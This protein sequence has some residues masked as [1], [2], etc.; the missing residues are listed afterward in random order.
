M[1]APGIGDISTS[2]RNLVNAIRSGLQLIIFFFLNSVRLEG[3]E[4]FNVEKATRIEVNS[5]AVMERTG[6]F[7][8]G[9]FVKQ[10]L[11]IVFNYKEEMESIALM[12]GCTVKYFG[13]YS[14]NR[15]YYLSRLVSP[16]F[17]NK[18]R[19]SFKS[20]QPSFN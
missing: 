18:I 14:M 19:P 8:P 3:W 5:K 6:H 20:L 16:S 7:I 11:E 1:P 12:V 13:W 4:F 9:D 10:R 17:S 15:N 2:A